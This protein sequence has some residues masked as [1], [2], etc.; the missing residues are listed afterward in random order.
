MDFREKYL[1]LKEQ[2]NQ[3]NSLKRLN[4]K[5]VHDLGN[6]L[7]VVGDQILDNGGH[8]VILSLVEKFN[9]IADGDL[10]DG[11]EISK[12][13]D[14]GKIMDKIGP[15]QCENCEIV[16]KYYDVPICLSNINMQ[17]IDDKS[18]K[19]KVNCQVSKGLIKFYVK[20]KNGNC[21]YYTDI[22]I[23]KMDM[24]NS[25]QQFTSSIYHNMDEIDKIGNATIIAITIAQTDSISKMVNNGEI[26]I[27]TFNGITNTI[28]L[29]NN[30]S[31]E[32]K[33]IASKS[34]LL[35]MDQRRILSEI[36]NQLSINIANIISKNLPVTN[37]AKEEKISII[38]VPGECFIPLQ[39]NHSVEMILGNIDNEGTTIKQANGYNTIDNPMVSTRASIMIDANL[40]I[41]SN[42]AKKNK[43]TY[44]KEITV[45]PMNENLGI[46]TTMQAVQA[47]NYIPLLNGNV[48][49]GNPNRFATKLSHISN[50]MFDHSKIASRFINNYNIGEKNRKL[51]SNNLST[52]YAIELPYQQKTEKI[53]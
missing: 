52:V 18:D 49:T 13:Y 20:Q 32:I 31:T 33:N 16:L 11:L 7:F 2:I 15:D 38:L 50:I 27:D 3:I 37:L 19:N 30:I 34:Q 25:L 47:V 42:D 26:N 45:I 5:L 44:N 39:A 12:Y 21:Y 53:E 43:D 6:V 24:V 10:A 51:L 28:Q 17:G 35:K 1:H 22:N 8:A 29:I 14:L 40:A 36:P 4:S 46:M 23:A 48:E 41:L 9:R